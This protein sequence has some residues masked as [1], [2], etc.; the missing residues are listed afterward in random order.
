MEIFLIIISK[1]KFPIVA[2][3]AAAVASVPA[4]SHFA[5]LSFRA[6]NFQFTPRSHSGDLALVDAFTH[7]YHLRFYRTHRRRVIIICL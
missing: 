7:R 4:K 1:L 3:T 2:Q 5:Q 6:V